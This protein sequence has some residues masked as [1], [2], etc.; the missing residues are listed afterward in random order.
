MTH[1]TTDA[2]IQI[3][4]ETEHAG[5]IKLLNGQAPP[6]SRTLTERG[7]TQLKLTDAEPP[8]GR[9]GAVYMIVTCVPLH[10]PSNGIER[11][12]RFAARHPAPSPGGRR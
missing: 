7:P 11:S 3:D 10:A 4:G 5:T 9:P 6:Y 1:R 12:G 8:D 2:W